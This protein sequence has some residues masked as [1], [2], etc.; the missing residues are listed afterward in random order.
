MREIN[1]DRDVDRGEEELVSNSPSPV[2][3]MCIA[4]I[5]IAIAFLGP[6]AIVVWLDQLQKLPAPPR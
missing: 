1:E 4:V 3:A 5:V 2:V 6:P